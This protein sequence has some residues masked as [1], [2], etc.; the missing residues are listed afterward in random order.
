M[1]KIDIEDASYVMAKDY[2]EGR[3]AG[4]LIRYL[5][6]RPESKQAPSAGGP[7]SWYTLPQEQQIGNAESFTAAAN[8]R[9]SAVFAWHRNKGTDIKQNFAP[10]ATSYV[11]VV[12]SPDSRN[13]LTTEQIA[14]LVEPWI[15]DGRGEILPHV[16]AVH[17]DGRR[18]QHVHIAIARDKFDRGELEGLKQSTR[19]MTRELERERQIVLEMRQE[20]N[21]GM[22]M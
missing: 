13:D 4:H 8:V 12:L 11:H 15:T 21:L 16:G 7:A 2:Y 19:G 17:T 14:S 6:R 9:T 20:M 18:G 3:D 10:W 1:E 22:E 5:W